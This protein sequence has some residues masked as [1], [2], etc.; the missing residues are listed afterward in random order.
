MDEKTGYKI[1]NFY[2]AKNKMVTP[3]CE[4]FQKWKNEKAP[5]QIIRMDKAGEN[6]KLKNELNNKI[7]KMYPTIEWTARDT[8]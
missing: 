3:M 8:P 6:I 1:S 2:E 4:L 5:V 7:W